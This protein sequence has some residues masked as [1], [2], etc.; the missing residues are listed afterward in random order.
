MEHPRSVGTLR[1]RRRRTP[2]GIA[3]HHQLAPGARPALVAV[4]TGRACRWVVETP[5][6]VVDL[7]EADVA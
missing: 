5:A 1:R 2:G 4:W 7:V 3:V 6:V